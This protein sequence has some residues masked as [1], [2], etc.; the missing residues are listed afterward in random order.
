MLATNPVARW[1]AEYLG[2]GGN[3]IKMIR[4]ASLV[5]RRDPDDIEALMTLAEAVPSPD[6]RSYHY[7]T[8]ARVG[9]KLRQARISA[10]R[11]GGWD[12]PAT[13]MFLYALREVALDGGREGRRDI[14]AACVREMLEIDPEDHL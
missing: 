10:G 13:R 1:V 3:P 6:E 12:D 8:A 2:R 7:W 11:E 9:R 4:A 5:L 14:A